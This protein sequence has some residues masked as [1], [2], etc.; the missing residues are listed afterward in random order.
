MRPIDAAQLHR[1]ETGAVGGSIQLG[2]RW[3]EPPAL[4]YVLWNTCFAAGTTCIASPQ[5]R[6]SLELG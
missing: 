5:W 1:G 6:S 4:K 3:V 2:S